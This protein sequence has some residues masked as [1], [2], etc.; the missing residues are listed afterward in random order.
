MT[1]DERVTIFSSFRIFFCLVS[2]KADSYGCG[3]GR[4]MRRSSRY[5]FYRWSKTAIAARKSSRTLLSGGLPELTT[6]PCLP[7]QPG[8]YWWF[9]RLWAGLI[10]AK[11]R[12]SLRA[13][14][15]ELLVSLRNSWVAVGSPTTRYDFH[16]DLPLLLSFFLECFPRFERFR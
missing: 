8:V 14:N 11:K 2:T 4:K 5:H 10:V 3:N 1:V 16:A 9:L 7:R 12:N 13:G 6:Y 15:V